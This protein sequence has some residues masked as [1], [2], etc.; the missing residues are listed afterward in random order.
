[1]ILLIMQN[2]CVN[3]YLLFQ[4]GLSIFIMPKLSLEKLISNQKNLER[5]LD[6]LKDGII[7]HDLNRR[8]FYFNREAEEITGYSR[9]EVIGK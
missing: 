1:M 2:N 5:V 3:C 6:N 7:A 9:K 8:I 4:R